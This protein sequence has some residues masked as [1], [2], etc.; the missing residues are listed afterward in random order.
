MAEL[1][2]LRH[3]DVIST[4]SGGSIVG[5]LY[6]LYLKLRMDARPNLTR[7]DYLEIVAETHATLVKAIKK[8]LR[9]LL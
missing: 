1:D 4:V 9:T 8:N 3:V 2:L 6:A 5:A 7:N